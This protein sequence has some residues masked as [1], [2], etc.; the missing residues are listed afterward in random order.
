MRV[1]TVV[2]YTLPFIAV[3]GGALVLLMP[4]LLNYVVAIYLILVGVIGINSIFHFVR[5]RTD[6]GRWLRSTGWAMSWMN[7]KS[8]MTRSLAAQQENVGLQPLSPQ[9]CTGGCAGWHAQR[10]WNKAALRRLSIELIYRVENED[11]VC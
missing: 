5:W 8:W 2:H 7:W 10:P 4:R 1:T 6:Q 9:V 3:A 11:K